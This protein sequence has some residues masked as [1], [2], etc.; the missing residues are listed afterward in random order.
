VKWWQ[1][2]LGTLLAMLGASFVAG[3]LWERALGV[4]MPPYLAGAIGGLAAIP[5]W[6]LLKR[7]EVKKRP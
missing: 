5:V 2:L 3:L 1:R 6:E 4:G 7:V